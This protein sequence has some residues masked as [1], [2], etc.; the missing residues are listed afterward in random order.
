[1]FDVGGVF[2]INCSLLIR[3]KAQCAEVYPCRAF[4]CHT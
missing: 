1:M 2:V 3:R 4:Y